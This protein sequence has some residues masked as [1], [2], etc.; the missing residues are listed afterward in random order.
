MKL[1]NTLTRKLENFIPLNPPKVGL[2]SCGPTVYDYAH[3]GHAR[4]YIFLDILKRT[5]RYLDYQ[6]THVMNITDVGHLVSEAD[7]GE[8]KMEKGARREGKTVWEIA[9]FYT[10]DFFQTLGKININKPDIVAKATDHI[11]EMID[12]IKILEQK[13]FTYKTADGIYFDTAKFPKYGQLAKLDIKGLKEGARVEVNREK[14]NPTD[15]ALWKFAYPKGRSFDNAQDDAAK[16]RQMEWD[17]PWG[18]GFPGWHIE[19][20][21]MS[22]KYLGDTIDVHT[23]GIEHIPVHHTNEIAQS[24]CATGKTFVR[25]WLH[26]NHLLV[27]GN[28]MSKSLGN[29]LRLTDIEKKGFEPLAVRYLFLTAH[30]RSIMN[31]EWPALEGAQKTLTRLRDHL[32]VFA[33]LKPLKSQLSSDKLAKIDG[34]QAR[35]NQFITDDLNMPLAV[36]LVWEVVKSN[37]PDYEK[38]ELI[39]GWDQVLGLNLNNLK[40]KAKSL[41]LNKEALQLVKE[42]E[43][44]RKKKQWEEAD[45]LRKQIEKK[46]YLIEDTLEGAKIRK[47]FKI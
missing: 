30:Y 23:G 14:R 27:N 37:I 32:A 24:E 20:S 19:C 5:L 26:A 16:R 2:Y 47:G 34:F 6:V 11:P 33:K 1:Y 10:E 25:Y 39:L 28:K 22:M 9:Q 13:G 35:F 46:G 7:S 15:F 8:D 18:T 42:R 21:A 38:R 29:F 41:K 43:E 4:T 17:S 44:L 36:A 40:L 12:L 45:E 31:F 3:I